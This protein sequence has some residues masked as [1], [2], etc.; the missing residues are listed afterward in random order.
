MKTGLLGHFEYSLE[1]LSDFKELVSIFFCLRICILLSLP[2]PANDMPSKLFYLKKKINRS[3]MLEQFASVTD[4][5]I[6]KY[7]E[8]C[9][10]RLLYLIF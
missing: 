6:K 1:Y 4:I 7:F 9:V 5:T 2:Y 3:T 10:Y 8:M